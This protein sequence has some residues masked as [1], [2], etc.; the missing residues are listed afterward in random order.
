[1][2]EPKVDKK[3]YVESKK[4]AE[5]IFTRWWKDDIYTTEQAIRDLQELLSQ[6]KP[7]VSR[8]VF[9]RIAWGILTTTEK[10]QLL[11]ENGVEVSDD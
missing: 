5:Q 9:D 11:K 6:Q 7:R 2:S 3:G 8:E 10:I 4:I 1:M